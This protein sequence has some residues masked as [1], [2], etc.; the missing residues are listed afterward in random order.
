MASTDLHTALHQPE[1]GWDGPMSRQH[2]AWYITIWVFALLVALISLAWFFVGKQN[3]PY[4]NYR[5]EPQ[6]FQAKVDEFIQKFDPN[7]TGVVEVPPGEDAYLLSSM[8]S[9]SPVIKVKNG[10]KFT[11]WYSSMDVV[12]TPVIGGTP[13]TQRL[14]FQA[15]PGHVQGI[16][17]TPNKPG[18][19]LIYC[20]EYCGLGHQNMAT[21]LIVE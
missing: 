21:H 7:G 2:F 20:A 11:I 1:E 6:E 12:H 14:A 18:T 9:F 3:I 10:Q 8:W 13:M 17:F 15:V 5:M 16:S 4:R 19:Y